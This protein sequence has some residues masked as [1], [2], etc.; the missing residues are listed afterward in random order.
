[1]LDLN[2]YLFKDKFIASEYEKNLD[3]NI[4]NARMTWTDNVSVNEKIK[5]YENLFDDPSRLPYFDEKVKQWQLSSKFTV[6]DNDKP[7][8]VYSHPFLNHI[9]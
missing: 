1:M 7:D 6:E 5:K 9:L 8:E 4:K 2:D 3:A